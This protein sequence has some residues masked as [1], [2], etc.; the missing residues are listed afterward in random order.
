LVNKF[1]EAKWRAR[2]GE[3]ENELLVLVVGNVNRLSAHL[4]LAEVGKLNIGEIE[5]RVGNNLRRHGGGF[6]TI[7]HSLL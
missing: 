4:I 7:L 6:Y 5:G 2:L 1:T 3:L